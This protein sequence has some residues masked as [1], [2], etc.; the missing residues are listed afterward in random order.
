VYT[1]ALLIVPPEEPSWMLQETAKLTVPVIE[2]VNMRVSP[3]PILTAAGL[4]LT[5]TTGTVTAAVA[6]LVVSAV[7]VATT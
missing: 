7:L 6:A 2:A 3:V 1:P 5:L 4:R